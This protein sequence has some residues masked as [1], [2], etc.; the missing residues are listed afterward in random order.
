MYGP[1][2]GH[3]FKIYA[4]ILGPYINSASVGPRLVSIRKSP[5]SRLMFMFMKHRP[6]NIE[7]KIF[8]FMFAFTVQ[9]DSGKPK[10]QGLEYPN[11]R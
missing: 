3:I 7:N 1:E 9:P 10:I 5:I 6:Q 4:R 11:Q 8:M 2:S